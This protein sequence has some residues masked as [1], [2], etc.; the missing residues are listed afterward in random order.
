MQPFFPVRPLIHRAILTAALALLWVAVYYLYALVS[1][2]PGFFAAPLRAIEW[3][4]MAMLGV[5]TPGLWALFRPW[6]LAA[7]ARRGII[8]GYIAMM[9]VAFSLA[10]GFR[11][12][13]SPVVWV[14]G[15]GVILLIGMAL[16]YAVARLVGKRRGR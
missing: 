10:L 4:P 12:L 5:I 8:I 16:G 14:P 13:A 2:G 3:L 1:I 11:M 7:G 6:R 15:I 9:P